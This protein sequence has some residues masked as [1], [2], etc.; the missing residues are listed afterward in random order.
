[1]A[2]GRKPKLTIEELQVRFDEWRRN[3]QGKS[4]IPAELWDAAAAVARRDGVYQTAKALHLD[5]A[6]LKQR[7]ALPG[8]RAPSSAPAF[9]E[10]LTGPGLR[11][12][13]E[14]TLEVEGH[15]GKLRIHCKGASTADVAAL[16][17]ALWDPAR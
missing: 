10:L 12:G 4:A 14:Y 16:G 13:A 8:D 5:G 15:A 6:K 7:M 3:R 2:R 9:L 1:M 17:R 11:A